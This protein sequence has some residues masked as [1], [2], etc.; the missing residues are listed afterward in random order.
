[1]VEPIVVNTV[2]NTTVSLEKL[3]FSLDKSPFFL[4]EVVK[5]P[6]KTSNARREK[7]QMDRKF[8]MTANITKGRDDYFV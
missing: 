1:V 3:K 5:L 6:D 4:H 8:R 2:S 7:Y